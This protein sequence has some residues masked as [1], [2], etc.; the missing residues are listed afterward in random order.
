MQGEGGGNAHR[1]RF[2]RTRFTWDLTDNVGLT[3]SIK[4]KKKSMYQNQQRNCHTDKRLG[5]YNQE[6][7]NQHKITSE[8]LKHLYTKEE[9]ISYVN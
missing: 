5:Y 6:D 2:C 3:I 4:L 7:K 1:M 8:M 9:T